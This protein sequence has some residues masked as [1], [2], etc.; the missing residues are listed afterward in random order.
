MALTE[1]LFSEYP[2]GAPADFTDFWGTGDF[3]AIVE[4]NAGGDIDFGTKWLKFDASAAD[5][6]ALTWDDLGSMS[7]VCAI[8]KIRISTVT[9]HGPV[10]FLRVGGAATTEDAYFCA[11]GSGN[12]YIYK[13][14]NGATTLLGSIG[15]IGVANKEYWVKSQAIGTAIKAKIWAAD[16]IE[17]DEWHLE[18]TDS[19]IASGY[20]GIGGIAA[21]DL[22]YLDY[23]GVDTSEINLPTAYEDEVY[24]GPTHVPVTSSLGYNYAMAMGGH[25]DTASRKLKGVEIYCK[26]THNDQVRI[27][28]YSGGALD[29]GPQGATLLKDFGLTSGSDVNQWIEI[30]TGDDIDIPENAP[31]WIVVK[32]DNGTGFYFTYTANLGQ[33]GDFQ[34]ARGRCDVSGIIGKDPDVA[35]PNPFTAGSASFSDSIWNFRIL[36]EE[37][38]GWTGKVCGVTNPAKINGVAV[39]NIA[40]VMGQ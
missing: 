27:G 6:S 26:T 24:F 34:I 22:F 18:A 10:V 2:N 11:V 40:S 29:T 38:T 35:F 20:V 15:F 30:T 12:I 7:D 32:G 8:A 16:S 5:R 23:F 1:T 31:L 13:Y 14:V 17:P 4:S 33:C 25:F 19:D 37:S 28:I 9:T 36:T 39:A 3:T 21:T